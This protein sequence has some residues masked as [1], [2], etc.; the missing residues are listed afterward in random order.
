MD[1]KITFQKKVLENK[2]Q[3]N[4]GTIAG[5]LLEQLESVFSAESDVASVRNSYQSLINNNLS[6]INAT[7]FPVADVKRSESEAKSSLESNSSIDSRDSEKDNLLSEIDFEQLW[8]QSLPISDPILTKSASIAAIAESR[9]TREDL[10]RQLQRE[11]VKRLAAIP[12]NVDYIDPDRSN[13]KG[14]ASGD[15]LINGESCCD[16]PG[17]SEPEANVCF[18][19]TATLPQTDND[20][21]DPESE[22]FDT[23][24]Q[25][26]TEYKAIEQNNTGLKLP[27]NKVSEQE[28]ELQKKTE[29]NI[30]DQNT[31]D[32]DSTS[33]YSSEQDSIGFS[34]GRQ[35][36][37]NKIW[38]AD[39]TASTNPKET[40]IETAGKNPKRG[41]SLFRW[42]VAIGLLGVVMGL[43]LFGQESYPRYMLLSGLKQITNL[44]IQAGTIQE[45]Y[46]QGTTRV[47]P[48]FVN[49]SLN[50]PLFR[51]ETAAFSTLPFLLWKEKR[52]DWLVL[53][54][55]EFD[56]N[57]ISR[58]VVIS[59]L[60]I[61]DSQQEYE[62]AI[63]NQYQP[64]NDTIL[65]SRIS[66]QIDNLNQQIDKSK[67]LL[68]QKLQTIQ[69]E[70]Q[71]LQER[72]S[73]NAV[74]GSLP[75]SLPGL[76]PTVSANLDLSSSTSAIV[77]R[78]TEVQTILTESFDQW[79]AEKEKWSLAE[80]ELFEEK[81]VALLPVG[82]AA[83]TEA[84]NLCSAQTAIVPEAALANLSSSIEENQ[85]PGLPDD[86][87]SGSASVGA[88]VGSS[89]TAV[90]DADK[91]A[92][93]LQETPTSQNNVVLP[94][95]E[96]LPVVYEKTIPE[97]S[98][99]QFDE[100]LFGNTYR[101]F[102]NSFCQEIASFARWLPALQEA[103]QKPDGTSDVLRLANR[104]KSRQSKPMTNVTE[105]KSELG[106]EK[107]PGKD[108]TIDELFAAPIIINPNIAVGQIR[109]SGKIKFMGEVQPFTGVV[110]NLNSGSETRPTVVDLTFNSRYPSR[111]RLVA[112]PTAD[113]KYKI[114]VE[115]YRPGADLIPQIGKPNGICLS[116][117]RPAAKENASPSA[118]T[119]RTDS[120][121]MEIIDGKLTGEYKCT[122][123]NVASELFIPG[124]CSEEGLKKIHFLSEKIKGVELSVKLGGS[125]LAPKLSCWSNIES[126]ERGAAQ[127]AQSEQILQHQKNVQTV[128]DQARQ[129]LNQMYE[130]VENI[131]KKVES[132][133]LVNRVVLDQ[134]IQLCQNRLSDKLP[135]YKVE[136]ANADNRTNAACGFNAGSDVEN[137]NGKIE[138]ASDGSEA[139][140]P[141]NNREAAFESQ[142]APTG[143]TVSS[144]QSEELPL[145]ET[146]E[147][148][149]QDSEMSDSSVLPGL[150]ESSESEANQA[151]NPVAN[152]ATN[153]AAINRASAISPESESATDLAT[154]PAP[155]QSASP[156]PDYYRQ[157]NQQ[158]AEKLNSSNPLR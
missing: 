52:I 118:Q 25:K 75:E 113:N 5:D 53:D 68:D 79:R 44:K 41:R 156:A 9:M 62:S 85:L 104:N 120:V 28:S 95:S 151:T 92:C 38:T 141:T 139:G 143:Q 83:G 6:E 63:A 119:V 34:S 116:F 136:G 8:R 155:I 142:I 60:D 4:T 81:N 36:Y 100:Y 37:N 144:I 131:H 94:P 67:A 126:L 43:V 97:P 123:N 71:R 2:D 148:S 102:L 117:F 132:I 82:K 51:V 140:L 19:P 39:S 130:K 93:I 78:A 76:Y 96:N 121:Q 103:I 105:T 21:F 87:A 69:T 115:Y 86:F 101:P 90:N 48:V 1:E 145:K 157:E 12:I 59:G 18:S 77:Q 122:Q 98:P 138:S 64:Y 13:A 108:K 80:N 149:V 153:P 32:H 31:T 99:Q 46:K 107:S 114:S 152:P 33:Q 158:S 40:L 20:S 84:G 57:V 88:A 35:N 154:N 111:L 109:L 54:G 66:A 147:T 22:N 125:L 72:V 74:S 135:E 29:F 55:L 49:D 61:T 23:S 45:N 91:N 14:R 17:V 47:S 70:T 16:N 129:S 10:E 112:I 15:D 127:I 58:P 65:R 106:S 11:Q 3:D 50:Q 124:I 110:S 42:A 146:T 137:P 27:K 24:E 89:V 134:T 150:P 56:S 7:N 133:V 128:K 30:S 26:L 73:Q